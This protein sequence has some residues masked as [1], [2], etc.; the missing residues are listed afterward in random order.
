VNIA[1]GVNGG[2]MPLVREYSNID[3]AIKEMKSLQVTYLNGRYNKE[4]LQQWKTADYKGQNG[5]EY[6]N[7]HLGYRLWLG[8]VKLSKYMKRNKEFGMKAV[9]HNSG[10]A[11]IDKDNE[12]FLV[13]KRGEK[14]I[15][16]SK[17]KGELSSINSDMAKEFVINTP[18]DDLFKVDNKEDIL[19]GVYIANSNST[20]NASHVELAN[21]DVIYESGI[22]YFAKYKFDNKKYVLDQI[23]NSY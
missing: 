22:N 4:V 21:S 1:H 13:M 8:E 18:I 9:I 10:F 11:P 23:S 7:N 14:I 5:L 3:N 17:L 16:K 12:M 15:F 20:N 2:E 19:V 6:I